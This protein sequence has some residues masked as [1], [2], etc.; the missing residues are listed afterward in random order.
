MEFKIF[1]ESF[2]L[3]RVPCANDVQSGCYKVT[4]RF[5]RRMSNIFAVVPSIAL[6]LAGIFER[7]AAATSSGR[8]R[9]P[10]S[11]DST[12]AMC[13]AEAAVSFSWSMT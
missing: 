2:R 7:L 5:E 8:K 1:V 13:L 6:K 11:S 10:S 3:E 9:T 12:A 4:I